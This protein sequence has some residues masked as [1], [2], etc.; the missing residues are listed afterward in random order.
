MILNKSEQDDYQITEYTKDGTTVSHTVRVPIQTE[1][2]EPVEV[3]PQ[4]SIEE[5]L[6]Q[7]ELSAAQTLMQVDYLAF[8]NEISTMKGGEE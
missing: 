6:K 3:E 7:I 1:P 5:R 2:I 4:P 8:M